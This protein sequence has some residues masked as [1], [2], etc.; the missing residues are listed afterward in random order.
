MVL[1]TQ[2][3]AVVLALAYTG[4]G[5]QGLADNFNESFPENT[6]VQFNYLP[7][8]RARLALS[9]SNPQQA[10]DTLEVTAPYELGLPWRRLRTGNAILPSISY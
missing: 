8:L 2:C 10:L 4:D 3:Y 7:T 9:H 1:A 5:S 6:L